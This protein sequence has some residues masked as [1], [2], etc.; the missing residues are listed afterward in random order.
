MRQRL[1]QHFLHDQSVVDA[2][3]KLINTSGKHLIVEVGPGTGV[4]TDV[5]LEKSQTVLA[6]EWDEELYQRLLIKYANNDCLTLVHAD[7]RHY[8]LIEKINAMGYQSYSVVANLPY[9][10]SSYLFRQIFSYSHLPSQVIVLIQKEVAQRISAPAGSSDRG[11]LSILCQMYGTPHIALEVAPT[12]FTPPPK[13]NSAVLVLENISNNLI[14]DINQKEL[15][16]VVK[17]G[18]GE[19]RKTLENALAGGLMISKDVA[20]DCLRRAGIDEGLRAQNLTVE[21]WINLFHATG[22]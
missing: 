18:F 20:Q 4:L 3:S 11:V 16:R 15:M 8:N 12:S 2:M 6:I 14:K 13:V 5:L 22:V 10:L 1:G 9:Y 17:A 21:Q 7:I 19:K